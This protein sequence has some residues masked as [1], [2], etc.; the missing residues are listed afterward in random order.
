M[1]SIEA[2]HTPYHLD[3]EGDITSAD[4]KPV[5]MFLNA[6][7]D[8]E[9]KQFLVAVNSYADNRRLIDDMLAA[10]K[11][12]RAYMRPVLETLK[13]SDDPVVNSA[14]A[15]YA[16]VEAAIARAEGRS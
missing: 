4:G 6:I 10:L 8:D 13:H 3:E 16:K 5:A 14:R 15:D 1:T 9:A 12:G 11:I 7:N 2:A